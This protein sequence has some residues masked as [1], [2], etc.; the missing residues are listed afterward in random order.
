MLTVQLDADFRVLPAVNSGE[1]NFRDR[2]AVYYQPGFIDT[3]TALADRI[4]GADVLPMPDEL[5]IDGGNDALL[6]PDIV[7]GHG[8]IDILVMLAND[9]AREIQDLAGP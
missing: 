4:G 8:S 1:Q 9:H 3:A 6:G 2:S 5:P 7:D